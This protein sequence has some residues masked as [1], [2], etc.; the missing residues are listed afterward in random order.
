MLVELVYRSE[1]V[2]DY[3]HGLGEL[4]A[5]LRPAYLARRERYFAAGEPDPPDPAV[6]AEAILLATNSLRPYALRARV[7]PPEG[8]RAP[9]RLAHLLLCGLCRERSPRAR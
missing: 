6:A 9:G 3:S 7:G 4:F 2:R 5:S 8:R 1:I